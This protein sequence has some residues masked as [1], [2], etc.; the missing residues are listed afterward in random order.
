MLAIDTMKSPS[1]FRSYDR[2]VRNLEWISVS[3]MSSTRSLV[4]VGGR[5]RVTRLS[6]L[7]G[8]HL[9]CEQTLSRSIISLSIKSSIFAPCLLGPRVCAAMI[10]WYSFSSS[11]S[12]PPSME[13]SS[14]D[15]ALDSSKWCLL[16]LLFW[17]NSEEASEESASINLSSS[18][19]ITC[20]LASVPCRSPAFWGPIRE[21]MMV[22]ILGI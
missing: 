7:I 19:A 21:D 2:C 10:Y 5:P 1:S 4:L 22:R 16:F 14:S 18:S 17:T 9:N 8:G 15:V 11:S 12:L 13:E 6:S 3:S 20:I